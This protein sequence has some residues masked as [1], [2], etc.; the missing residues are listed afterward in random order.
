M[1][2]VTKT[3]GEQREVKNLGWLVRKIGQVSLV[4]IHPQSH[5][6]APRR[7]YESRMIVTLRDGTRYATDW[8]STQVCRDWLNRRRLPTDAVVRFF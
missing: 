8:A 7:G 6:K 5:F 3:N 1:A 4:E 2:T